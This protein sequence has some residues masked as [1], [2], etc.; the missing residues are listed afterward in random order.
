MNESSIGVVQR[1]FMHPNYLMDRNACRM[2]NSV[3]QLSEAA[4][5]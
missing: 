5:Q 3:K 2:P 4:K 1:W